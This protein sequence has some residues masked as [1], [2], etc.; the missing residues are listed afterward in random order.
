MEL[1]LTHENA[2]FDAVASVLA[3]SKLYPDALPVLPQRQNQNVV[4]FL[5]LYRNGLPFVLQQD[6]RIKSVHRVVL[7]DTQRTIAIKNLRKNIETE[8]IDHHPLSVELDAPQTFHYEDVGALTTFFVE[9]I[10][11]KGVLLTSLEATLLLL[12]IY[13]DTGSLCYGTTKPRDLQAA[14]WLLQ[15]RALL[16]IVR[17][18]LNPSMNEEQQGLFETLLKNTDTRLVEGYD[19]SIAV[20][21][22]D[23]YIS[24]ISIVAHRLRDVLDSSALFVLVAMPSGLLMVARSVED[25]IDVGTI[26]Q[27]LGGGGHNRA[28]AATV[29]ELSLTETLALI[30]NVLQTQVH[31]AVR[32]ADL[33][34]Y[35][36]HTVDANKPLRD[37]VRRLR[38]VGHEGYPVVD[39]DLLVGLLTRRD[40]D[41]ADEHGLLD[42][43][44]RDIMSAG[45]VK[46]L[47][48]DSVFTLEQRMLESGWG[49][50]PVTNPEGKIVGI[51]TRT[52]LIKHWSRTHPTQT[53]A[54]EI[55]EAGRFE[56]VLGSPIAQI[57]NQVAEVAQEKGI[58]LYLV[59]GV[60]RDL[61]LG[62]PNLDLDFVVEGDAIQFAE[63]VKAQLGGQVYAFK[64]FGTAKWVMSKQVEALDHIDFASARFEFYEHPTALPTVYSSSIKL[65]L[66][67]RDFTINS[68]AAQVS[69]S[70][71]VGR[72]LDYYGG[73]RDLESRCIRVLHSLS[74]ID[75]PTR[76]LRAV[77]F[78]HRLMFQ[79]EERTATLM[80]TAL[81]MLQ[82]VTGERLRNEINLLLKEQNPEQ[83]LL[84]LQQRDILLAIHPELNFTSE[85]ITKFGQVRQGNRPWQSD[86]LIQLDLD[87]HLLAAPMTSDQVLSISERLLIG[88][89]MGE[90]LI[91]AAHIYEFFK[92]AQIS[93]LLPS[94][95]THVL[96]TASETALIAV[97]L[98]L[99]DSKARNAIQRYWLEWRHVKP[100][101][102][103][104][105][106][107]D[108]GLRP[109][110]CYSRILTRIR[111]ARLDGKIFTDSEERAFLEFLLHDERLCDDPHE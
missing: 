4:R 111:I 95:I 42:M 32:V 88:R 104:D 2:D 7:V 100:L 93:A 67:R 61:L 19:I 92:N 80:V 24:E 13:E 43:S 52:D 39:H 68:L 74:F 96:R 105:T 63:A 18:F 56:S 8:I 29:R 36:A 82:R 5:T 81:P 89:G 101:T 64:P 26:A 86:Q 66:Q 3:A 34:S 45:Q 11:E 41:R 62:R 22:V 103:G 9:Q 58:G 16:D 108:M 21:E 85:Q 69:P 28:A 76:I 72:I 12:G 70:A 79:I 102:N 110:P 107:R 14:A 59:G 94:Q 17:R 49:Q 44:V 87:W 98:L 37:I 30:W 83:G 55:I 6:L 71:F 38:Q 51:V 91:D 65:D 47:P 31:P 15:Q 106:L 48:E 50:I 99:D 33:M 46:L 23:R 78:E 1:I 75:D 90:S 54:Y 60:V 35:S 97:W 53:K 57:I 40:L 25:A 20:A 109:G 77:R 73:L 84:L 27:L 10:Q